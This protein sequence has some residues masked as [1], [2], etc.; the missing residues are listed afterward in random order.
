MTVIQVDASKAV[1]TKVNISKHLESSPH[2]FKLATFYYYQK[3][4]NTEI[5]T[6]GMTVPNS[7]I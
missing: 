2:I 1:Q 4:T 5:Y 6:C 7:Q 3:N